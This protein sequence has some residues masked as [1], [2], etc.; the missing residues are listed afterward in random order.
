MSNI[1]LA[2][3]SQEGILWFQNLAEADPYGILPLGFV[4]PSLINIT[5]SNIRNLTIES[6]DLSLMRLT[7]R[8][9]SIKN[10]FHSVVFNV[11]LL[12][13]SSLALV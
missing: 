10:L 12:D 7:N 13:L 9:Q 3:I 4:I 1:I 6:F 11:V 5:V 8:V 2:T